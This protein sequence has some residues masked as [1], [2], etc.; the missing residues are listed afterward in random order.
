M[1]ALVARIFGRKIPSYTMPQVM[2]H[3]DLQRKANSRVR[4]PAAQKSFPPMT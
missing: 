1:K 2:T 3:E 4:D